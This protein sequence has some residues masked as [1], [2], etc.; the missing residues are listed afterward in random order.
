MRRNLLH[1][2][3][4]ARLTL[5]LARACE[6]WC[7]PWCEELSRRVQLYADMVAEPSFHG[8]HTAARWA[9]GNA[10]ASELHELFSWVEATGPSAE[11]SIFEC[12]ERTQVIG[13]LQELARGERGLW[14]LAAIKGQLLARGLGLLHA[15][16]S[17]EEIWEDYSRYVE[18]NID[19][20]L[21]GRLDRARAL[22]AAVS[23][24]RP[25][26][27]AHLVS[28]VFSHSVKPLCPE[29]PVISLRSGEAVDE[30]LPAGLA[31][32]LRKHWRAIADEA[33]SI[34]FDGDAWPNIVRN[35]G[36]WQQLTLYRAGGGSSRAMEE[37][38]GTDLAPGW[39]DSACRLMPSTCELLRG[40]L[41]S[42][43]SAERAAFNRSLTFGNDEE[44]VVF[45]LAPRSAVPFHHGSMA[46]VNVQLCLDYCEHAQV[47]V[48]DAAAAYQAGELVAFSDSTLHGA[49]NFDPEAARLIMTVG[50]LH[51]ELSAEHRLCDEDVT[52]DGRAEDGE[53]ES[54]SEASARRASVAAQAQS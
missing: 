36:R 24:W 22:H 27:P 45:R 2:S 39:R 48:G 49:A 8:V 41:R 44:V 14:E 9:D 23:A 10:L 50:V 40:R 25:S 16:R 31:D 42:E 51:P 21:G 33:R 17:A 26:L 47:A 19:Y 11:R 6:P 35:G 37:R 53:S 12:D 46:R 29:L 3:A 4:L 15:Q 32:D 52:L 30:L 5:T 1:A 7:V 54:D 13:M 43:R 28:D 20:V 38:D 18:V 34:S